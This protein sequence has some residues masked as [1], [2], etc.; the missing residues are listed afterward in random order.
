MKMIWRIRAIVG[1]IQSVSLFILS[2]L[3]VA[4][5]S[6]ESESL[7]EPD[8]LPVGP[9]Q[10]P[11]GTYAATSMAPQNA[12][13]ATV[14]FYN[15]KKA[16]TYTLLINSIFQTTFFR[17]VEFFYETGSKCRFIEMNF[18]FYLIIQG[19]LLL[20]YFPHSTSRRFCVL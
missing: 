19:R 1:H 16:L 7:I 12:R 2:N 6:Q 5:A 13:S 17:L 14:K 18:R 15:S 11:T 4:C 10:L 3:L 20:S 8:T 9:H